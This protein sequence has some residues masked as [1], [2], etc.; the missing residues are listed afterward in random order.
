[1]F[2]FVPFSPPG[3]PC[4]SNMDN[5]DIGVLGS[6]NPNA[7]V[8]THTHTHTHNLGIDVGLGA[9]QGQGPESASSLQ[10]FFFSDYSSYSTLCDWAGGINTTGPGI[11]DGTHHHD[12]HANNAKAALPPYTCFGEN[13]SEIENSFSF[14]PTTSAVMDPW[15]NVQDLVVA[16]PGL[17]GLEDT[18]WPSGARVAAPYA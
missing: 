14:L 16:R 12:H 18:L 13:G 7:N 4:S 11:I 17:D 3:S 1:M 10:S 2:D 9:G 6:V 8:G 15:N 5:N